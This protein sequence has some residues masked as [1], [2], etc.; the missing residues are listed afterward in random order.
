[1][2]CRGKV[3]EKLRGT[4]E[5]ARGA[6]LHL[7]WQLNISITPPVPVQFLIK[8]DI[9]TV[10]ASIRQYPR[11]QSSATVTASIHADSSVRTPAGAIKPTRMAVS[12]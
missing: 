2:P 8:D 3:L 9:R 12:R 4:G 5:E 6:G 7:L 11:A 1:M 10:S